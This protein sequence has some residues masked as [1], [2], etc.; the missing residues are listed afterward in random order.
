MRV[1]LAEDEPQMA[2]V[3]SKY[4]REQGY[5]VDIAGDGEQ[6]LYLADINDYDLVTLDVRFVAI[7]QRTHAEDFSGLARSPSTNPA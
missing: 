2:G 7:Q 6:A 4:L 1:L 3:I 5:A